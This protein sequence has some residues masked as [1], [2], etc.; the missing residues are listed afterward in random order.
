MIYRDE[1]TDLRVQIRTEGCELTESEKGQIERDLGVLRE[2]CSD[3][4]LPELHLDIHRHPQRRVFHVRANLHASKH[5][6]FTGERETVVVQAVER[7]VRKLL[8][9]LKCFK[10]KHTGKPLQSRSPKGAVREV[11]PGAEPDLGALDRAA[12]EMDYPAF[13]EAMSVYDE[14]LSMRVGRWVSRYPELERRL[15]EETLLS[16]IVEEVYL[17][18]FERFPTRS[19]GPVSTWLEHL[20]DPSIR[21]LLAHPDSEAERLEY[22]EGLGAPSD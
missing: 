17:N 5:N 20:I 22:F 11:A 7:C 21:N 4:P 14:T 2:V 15:G 19:A 12:R 13:R 9:K 18:A 10:E 1:A 8:S 6:F 16:D 3:F